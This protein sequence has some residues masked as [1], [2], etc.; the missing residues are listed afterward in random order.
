MKHL[1]NIADAIIDRPLLWIGIRC[2]FA[3]WLLFALYCAVM[4]GINGKG[5]ITFHIIGAFAGGATFGD[6]LKGIL[7]DIDK[8]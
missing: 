6:L 2:L 5:D 1:T 3:A 4:N 7:K 8:L